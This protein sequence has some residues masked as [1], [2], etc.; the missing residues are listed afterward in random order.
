MAGRTRSSSIHGPDF[1]R[2]CTI[3]LEEPAYGLVAAIRGIA[4]FAWNPHFE[5]AQLIG[6]LLHL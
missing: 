3:P 6:V 5:T 2:L 4:H 1:Q